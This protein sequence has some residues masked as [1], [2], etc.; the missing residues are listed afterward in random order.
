MKSKL[1]LSTLLLAA[2]L[3]GGCQAKTTPADNQTAAAPLVQDTKTGFGDPIAQASA[4]IT[5]KHYGTYVTPQNSPVQPEKFTGYHTGT[6]FEILP[7]EEDADVE[8]KAI[9][10]GKLLQKRTATGYGGVA[11]Q[12]CTYQG[13]PI[14]IVYGHLKFTSITPTVGQ[15]LAAGDHLGI[16]GKGYSSETSG[17]RKHLH[18]GIHKGTSINILGYVQSQGA[19]SGW[20]DWEKI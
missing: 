14:T 11:V 3:L 5:K 8:V 6:D 16:L 9:C 10:N 2:L 17:E 1:S 20:L 4:R 18:L 12:A 19:L 13:Q 7:G 15:E